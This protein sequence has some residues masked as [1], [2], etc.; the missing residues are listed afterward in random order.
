MKESGM[1][2]SNRDRQLLTILL[3]IVFIFL[4]YYFVAGPAFDKG[5]LLSQDLQL[6]EENLQKINATIE[7]ASELR[8]KAES[9]KNELTEKYKLFLYDINEPKLINRMASL[10][11][12]TGFVVNNYQQSTPE[13]G[14][15]FFLSSEYTPPQ[16]S[17]LD[18]AKE[19]NPELIEPAPA[20][21]QE[22][23]S[24][25]N[26]SLPEAV[27]Q[28]DIGIG[29][30]GADY[31]TIRSFLKAIEGLER[32]FILSDIVINKD[33]QIAGLQGQIIIRAISL[34]KIDEGEADDLS[35]QPTI[36]QGRP[37]PF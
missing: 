20:E 36:P 24:E 27:E 6:A 13:L 18:I 11:G 32:S 25:A 10:M 16:Y 17:L 19:L 23:A 2:I 8:T 31:D 1:N 14:K 7:Q 30:S 4:A 22:S 33:A 3:A 15:I 37:N 12:T 28:M 26:S 21:S 5:V 9:K 35:F 34:P 29:F